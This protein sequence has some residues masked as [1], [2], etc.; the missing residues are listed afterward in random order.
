MGTEAL[1]IQPGLSTT[2]PTNR[3]SQTWPGRRVV[4]TRSAS[5]ESRGPR[6]RD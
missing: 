1:R 2:L 4:Q 5:H 6:V 3:T